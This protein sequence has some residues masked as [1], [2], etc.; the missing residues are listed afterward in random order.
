[1]DLVDLFLPVTCLLGQAIMV[2][3]DPAVQQPLPV[4]LRQHAVRQRG[5]PRGA[6]SHAT[7]ARGAHCGHADA[8]GDAQPRPCVGQ[9]TAGCPEQVRQQLYLGLEHSWDFAVLG[10]GEP[11]WGVL[12]G[13]LL[14]GPRHPRQHGL[15]PLRRVE[16]APMEGARIFAGVEVR[17]VLEPL[18][19]RRSVGVLCLSI[20]HQQG[21]RLRRPHHGPQHGLRPRRARAG[22]DRA[23]GALR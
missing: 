8:C 21:L 12:A 9:R 14:G 22:P 13:L 4:Q 23:C 6:D 2:L 10:G 1:M 16:G 7:L 20:N 18:D 5:L 17:H 11:I 15:L 19:H 3:L